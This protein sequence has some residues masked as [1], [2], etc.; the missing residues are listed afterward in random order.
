MQEK[1]KEEQ[2]EQCSPHQS[3]KQDKIKDL[4]IR[5]SKIKVES[6]KSIKNG[7]AL[8]TRNQRRNGKY[9]DSVCVICDRFLSVQ[10]QYTL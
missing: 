2:K 8:A 6:E 7:I 4:A 5:S 1:T 3:S 10:K 9:Q